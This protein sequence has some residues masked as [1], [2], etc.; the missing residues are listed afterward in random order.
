MKRIDKL[1]AQVRAM[2][3]RTAPIICALPDGTEKAMG[4]MEAIRAG[5]RFV[6]CADGCHGFDELYMAIL[7]SADLD[8]S[9]LEELEK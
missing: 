6:R 5:A 3:R 4:L 8:F 1:L 2:D 9:D 7:N